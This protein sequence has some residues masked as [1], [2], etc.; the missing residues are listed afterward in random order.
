MEKIENLKELSPDVLRLMAQKL[1]TPS[2]VSWCT[3]NKYFNKV[4][5]GSEVTWKNRIKEDTGVDIDKLKSEYLKRYID[6]Y[7]IQNTI[8]KTLEEYS[9]ASDKKIVIPKDLEAH[10]FLKY[11]RKI[12]KLIPEKII[13]RTRIEKLLKKY[14]AL[15]IGAD[16]F[17]IDSISHY[18]VMGD[19]NIKITVYEKGKHNFN[20]YFRFYGNKLEVNFGTGGMG[21]YN[22]TIFKLLAYTSKENQ[23]KGMFYR[24]LG[25]IFKYEI[26]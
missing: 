20:V 11:K 22:P 2:L 15:A 18:A 1:D 4:I 8:T 10:L 24:L 25:E 23:T 9:K 16:N 19:L 14:L 13:L 21:I 3:T 17:Y 5:C 12:N 26:H 6:L 7:R